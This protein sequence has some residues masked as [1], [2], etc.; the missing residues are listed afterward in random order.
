MQI[1]ADIYR[2]GLFGCRILTFADSKVE[3]EVKIE[4]SYTT[5][6]LEE[7]HSTDVVLG[8]QKQFLKM[9]WLLQNL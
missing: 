9:K 3:E 5:L 8:K 4:L 6:I 1:S 2:I 7:L